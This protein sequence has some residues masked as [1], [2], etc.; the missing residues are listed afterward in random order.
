[1]LVESVNT[2]PS[3]E[4]VTRCRGGVRKVL[5]GVRKV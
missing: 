1:M 2:R 3:E 4:G 5:L